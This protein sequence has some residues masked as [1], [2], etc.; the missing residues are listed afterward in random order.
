VTDFPVFR[1]AETPCPFCGKGIDSASPVD[2]SDQRPSDGDLSLCIYC[3]EWLVFN[4]D[5]TFRK[6]TD[7][8][9][10][11]IASDPALRRVRAAWRMTKGGTRSG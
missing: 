4:A 1:S 10:E 8:D 6:P 11:V 2:E 7:E 5:M 3:G 9:Y